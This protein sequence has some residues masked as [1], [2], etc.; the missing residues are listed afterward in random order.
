MH[1][2]GSVARRFT[3]W[4]FAGSHEGSHR[5]AAVTSLIGTAKLNGPDPEA[6]LRDRLKRIADHPVSRVAALLP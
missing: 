6:H 5:A 2:L 3:N 4:L 1:I